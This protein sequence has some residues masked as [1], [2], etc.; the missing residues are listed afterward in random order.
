M[1]KLIMDHGFTCEF[2]FRDDFQNSC[3]LLALLLHNS[4]A[5][6]C[7]PTYHSFQNHFIFLEWLVDKVATEAPNVQKL[8]LGNRLPE[9]GDFHTV[10]MR[11]LFGKISRI[12]NLQVLDAKA[13]K[14]SSENLS[15][16]AFH[17]KSLT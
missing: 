15:A 10:A 5:S 4:T 14:C 2:H 6:V 12:K 16:I 3:L 1:E 13:F 17:L 7:F 8:C 11:R 9:F